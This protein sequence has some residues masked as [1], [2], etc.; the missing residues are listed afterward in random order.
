MSASK[1][2]VNRA[3][4]REISGLPSSPT[5]GPAKAIPGSGGLLPAFLSLNE[6]G[7]MGSLAIDQMSPERQMMTNLSL[8]R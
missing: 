8:D 4:A 7:S 3:R 2:S 5:L 1:L 6:V